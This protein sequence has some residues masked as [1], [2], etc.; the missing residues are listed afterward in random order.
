MIHLKVF[1]S[2]VQKELRQ[3]RIAVSSFLATDD[4]LQECT[5]PRIF[6][7]YPQPLHP[8][9]KGYLDLLRTCQIY[10]L[11][12]GS[13]Y[14]TDAGNGLSATHEEYRL[15][16]ELRLPTLVCIKGS[17]ATLREP[18]VDEFLKEI[19]SDN[20]TYSRFT[21]E[22]QLLKAVGERLHEH[23]KT[24][25]ATVPRQA[26][27]EQSR[28]TLQS[29]SP[30]ERELVDGLTFDDMDVDIAH[31]MMAA[32]EEIDRNRL[33]PEDIPRLLLSRGYLW[34]DGQLLKPTI[35]GALLLA[36]RPAVVLPQSR[37]QLDAFS[38]TSRNADVVDSGILEGPLPRLIEQAVAF[39]RRNTPKPLVIKGLKRLQTETYP[40]EALR[41]AVVNAVAH[42][43]YSDAGA[44]ISIEV[45]ADRLLVSSPGDPPGGQLPKRLESGAARSRSRNPLIV[46]GLSWLELMDERGSGIPRMKRLLE[47]TGHPKPTYRIE[48]DSLVLEFQTAERSAEECTLGHQPA[49][50]GTPER[51]ARE[52]ILAEVKASGSIS[53]KICVQRLG[54][55]SAT[56]KRQIAELVTTGLLEKEGAARSTIYR[57]VGPNVN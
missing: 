35:A 47:Q 5:A 34:R 12:V 37:I 27:V 50:S 22:A 24:T 8:N 52:A 6:E 38:G 39:V 19:E 41:E 20:H 3:E 53:T 45:Y 4:F 11:I 42:R 31:D 46:Q 54:I 29:A 48:H 26:Q 55:P 32:A 33:K 56:A 17:R 51:T 49:S 15:A 10:L 16:Q 43:D 40:A 44:K 9:P 2:S 25:F 30:F 36:R 7:D 21:D 1:I 18:K 13:E 28:M 14:G 23:I 57:F